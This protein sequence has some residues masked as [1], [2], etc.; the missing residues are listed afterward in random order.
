MN[1]VAARAP[2]GDGEA[3]LVDCHAHVFTLHMPLSASAW[4]TPLR[5][6]AVEDYLATLDA[7]GVLFG[8]LSAASI[9]G[10]YNDYQIEATRRHRRLRTTIMPRP[11]LDR[12][13][14]ENMRRDGVV[15]IRLQW[16]HTPEQPDLTTP[17][18][19]VLLRRVADLGWHVH[20]HDDAPRLVEPL[21]HLHN[22]GV[23]VVVDHF[24]RADPARGIDC[25]GFTAILRSVELGNT[26]VKLSAGFRLESPDAPITYA[27]A[28]LRHAGADRLVWGSDW[29]F[30]AFEETVN[31]A[32]AIS[33]LAR[34]VPDPAARRKLAGETALRL[35]FA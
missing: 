9:Y 29:P 32:S 3:P 8:V 14:L 26:W 1:G 27:G 6:A 10:D 5:S 28:L 35:Y 12:Y 24:G 18:W 16:R 17:E 34:W 33:D 22:A 30:V 21:R 20:I 13:T 11:G 4:R 23:R 2:V 25:P 7:H 19:R 15:G 31:Y